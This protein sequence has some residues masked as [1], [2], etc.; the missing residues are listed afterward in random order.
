MGPDRTGAGDGEAFVRRAL[1]V[2]RDRYDVSRV[3]LAVV[4]FNERAR[5][6]YE[7][8]SF[9]SVGTTREE[10]NGGLYEFLWMERPL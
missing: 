4:S 9:E 2:A 7:R 8:C 5:R 3:R 10:T 1:V 6:V